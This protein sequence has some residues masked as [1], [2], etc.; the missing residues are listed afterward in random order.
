MV[1]TISW[2]G[3]YVLIPQLGFECV[4]DRPEAEDPG[5]YLWAVEHQGGYLIN[6]VGQT[7][8]NLKVRQRD[9]VVWGL[10]GR[11]GKVADPMQFRQGRLVILHTFTF[12]QFL[13]DYAQLSA[14][15]YETYQIMRVFI[16]PISVDDTIRSQI[17]SGIIRSLKAA[18]GSVA[19]F[20][21]N[22]NTV[23][24]SPTPLSAQITSGQHF[25]GLGQVIVC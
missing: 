7:R 13:A 12:S 4:F 10:G 8:N 16:A 25:H 3:P 19:D 6:Y 23:S 14:Q 2:L 15:T 21:K 17:E 1:V 18:G 9:D 22:K 24:P 11:E 5:V 20:L